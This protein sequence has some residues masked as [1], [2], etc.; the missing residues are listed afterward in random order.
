MPEKK[1][2]KWIKKRHTAVRNVAAFVLKPYCAVK[3][4]IKVKRFNEQGKRPYLIMLNHQ[5]VF[6]QFFVGM[7]F[8]GSVY[9][10]ASE[11]LFSNG[12]VSSLIRFLVDPI[13]IK[14]SV[15]DVRAVM[16]CMKVAREGGTIAIA[17]EG[18]RTYDG[19]LCY[20]KP[21]IVTLA[22]AL[23]LPIAFYRIEGGY[24]VHPRW[25]DV[26]RKGKM[27]GYVSKVIEYEDFKDMP[28]EDLYSIIL[29]ELNVD[30][31]NGK[32]TYKHKRLAE[33]LERVVYVCPHCG[34]SDFESNKDILK[35][36][37][38]GMTVKYTENKTFEAVCGEMPFKYVA[39]WYE[40]QNKYISRLDLS[41]FENKP[42]YTDIVKF[43]EVIPYKK[44]QLI[45]KEAV[46]SVWPDKITVDHSGEHSVYKFDSVS[47]A[48]VLGRNKLNIYVGSQIFQVYGGKRFCALKYLNLYYH[49]LNLS[50]KVS[51]EYLGL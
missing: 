32:G 34:L 17:P 23:K 7:A 10:V 21:S 30:E 14:K 46:L 48:A 33:Y 27:V 38:C 36:K 8:K 25:S 28:D 2:K 11:D 3:Y 42:I 20:I 37:K 5:T 4:G 13:P 44:K 26:V 29:R 35:C 47:S 18:N 41:S 24:G 22:K 40:Y 9:Y 1:K 12:P 43:S 6:D 45:S 49:A 15:N 19:K 50:K 16:N 39:D 51:N 31:A